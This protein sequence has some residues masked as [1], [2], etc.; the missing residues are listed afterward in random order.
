[1]I[2]GFDLQEPGSVSAGAGFTYKL[3]GGSQIGLRAFLADIDINRLFVS[4]GMCMHAVIVAAVCPVR[5]RISPGVR[6]VVDI[7]VGGT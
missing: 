5:L 6:A 1:M 7:L 3:C 2:T 4:T